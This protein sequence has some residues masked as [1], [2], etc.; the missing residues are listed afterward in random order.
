MLI[1]I[2]LFLC[3][4]G[5]VLLGADKLTEGAV[6]M[7]RH[8]HWGEWVI[9][10]TVVAFGTSLPE[11]AIGMAAVTKACGELAL[12][13]VVGSNIF[14]V[15]AIAGCSAL[16]RPILVSRS[17]VKKD[18]P[19]ALL[20]TIVLAIMSMDTWIDGASQNQ[21]SRT[22]GILL[23]GYFAVFMGYTCAS[24]RNREKSS[25]T[26]AAKEIGAEVAMPYWKI[27]AFMLIGIV[28]LFVGAIF[29]V[30]SIQ[31]LAIRWGVG[32]TWI[33]L[34]LLAFSTSLPELATSVIAARKGC[35][36]IAIGNVVGNNIFNIFLVLGL[37]ATVSPIPANGLSVVDW[38]LMLLSM[39][40]F[41]FFAYT[42]RG[43]ERWEGAAM[44]LLYGI[45]LAY[46][47]GQPWA[48][49]VF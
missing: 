19:F 5:L 45:C 40:S 49:S 20:A 7:A 9:G 23:L 37:C 39:L 25:C 18:I 17:T 2:V 48:L 27:S 34:T 22:D 3:G 13:N 16:M 12:G 21:L 44:L 42:K 31:E 28:C 43:I 14:N 10:L 36:A 29:C 38:G 30:D 24:A 6:G 33:G 47:S 26:E 11:W 15:L 8:C 1:A 46:W 32:E 41:W 35:S 4:I